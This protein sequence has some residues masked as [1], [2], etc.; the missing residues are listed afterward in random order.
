M[1]VFARL[2][3]LDTR[4]LGEPTREAPRQ[5]IRPTR[6]PVPG[7][8]SER[9]RRLDNGAFGEPLSR[10]A[11]YALLAV[12]RPKS[13]T[14][15]AAVALG[16]AV[17]AALGMTRVIDEGVGSI[18]CAVAATA[19]MGSLS[20]R[21]R[22]IERMIASSSPDQQAVVP[23]VWRRRPGLVATLF[24]GVAM[25]ALGVLAAV[26]QAPVAAAIWLGLGAS[27]LISGAWVSARRRREQAEERHP[28]N[29]GDAL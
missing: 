13:S 26:G 27:L 16:A 3:D 1:G 7:S 6:E 28:P 21:V 15:L 12:Q 17:L 10:E 24:P 8:L 4:V 19:I 11:A 20:F 25:I 22:T 2:R 5:E 29:I 23:P 9:L 14:R 18:V